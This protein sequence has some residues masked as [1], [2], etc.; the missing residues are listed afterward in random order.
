[1]VRTVDVDGILIANKRAPIVALVLA[2][3]RDGQRL[4]TLAETVDK[5]DVVESEVVCQSTQGG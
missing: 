5:I 1:M 3:G 4:G 2:V